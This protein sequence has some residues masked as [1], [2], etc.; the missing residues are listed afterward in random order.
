MTGLRDCHMGSLL[1][2]SALVWFHCI[3]ATHTGHH[4]K[5]C[6]LPPTR[7]P[8]YR[9]HR[10]K[11][12][13]I[14]EQGPVSFL[15]WRM[16]FFRLSQGRSDFRSN[17]YSVSRLCD[18]VGHGYWCVDGRMRYRAA[19]LSSLAIVRASTSH[20]LHYDPGTKCFSIHVTSNVDSGKPRLRC[21]LSACRRNMLL[22]RETHQKRP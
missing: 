8:E 3:A 12:R 22:H 20:V 5:V 13:I 14:V 21:S 18:R 10:R 11:Q 1:F 7:R 17:S 6:A 4:A 16:W 9:R 2:C 19:G 15:S